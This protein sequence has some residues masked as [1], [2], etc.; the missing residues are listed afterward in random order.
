[1]TRLLLPL[2]LTACAVEEWRNADIH[3]DVSGATWTDTDIA[4]LCVEGVGFQ[5]EALAAGR[6][7][8]P[9]IPLDAEGPLIID[10]IDPDN[11]SRVGR[12]GPI[13]LSADTPHQ[14]LSWAACDTEPCDSCTAQGD[15]ADPDAE[16]WL[17]GVRFR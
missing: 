4:R 5:E 7:G 14:E 6:I 10:I 2:L 9:G 8:F 17:L 13:A 12:A 16:S 3:V 1:M 11:D 15:R